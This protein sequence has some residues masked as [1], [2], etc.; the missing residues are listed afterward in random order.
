MRKHPIPVESLTLPSSFQIYRLIIIFT[1]KMLQ[2]NIPP[3]VLLSSTEL[4]E[5]RKDLLAGNILMRNMRR[6]N[7]KVSEHEISMKSLQGVSLPCAQL[8]DAEH[9][10]WGNNHTPNSG[11]KYF[12]QPTCLKGNTDLQQHCRPT[13]TNSSMSSKQQILQSSGNP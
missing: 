6:N 9:S 4:V 2:S 8:A 10:R 11:N 13:E 12:C 3:A 5:Q 1:E 7:P